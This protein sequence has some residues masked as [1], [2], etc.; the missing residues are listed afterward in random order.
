MAATTKATTSPRSVNDLLVRSQGSRISALQDCEQILL[1][2]VG[3]QAFGLDP[4]LGRLLLAQEVERHL[5]QHREVLGGVPL[6][7][8][9]VVLEI[10]Q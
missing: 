1:V 10:A 9:A 7:H 6:A 8:A 3:L 2:P 4:D 5:A